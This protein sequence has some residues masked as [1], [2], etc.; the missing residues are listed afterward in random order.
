MLELEKA[1]EISLDLIKPLGSQTIDIINAAGRYNSSNLKS[2]V[3]LPGFDNSAMD[4]YAIISSDLKQANQSNPVTLNCI[5]IAPAGTMPDKKIKDGMCIR[6]FTGSPIP[7]GANAVIMQE[8]CVHNDD[9]TIITSTSV[10]PWQ[11]IRIRGEDIRKG[12]N[13]IF[14]GEQLNA[15]AIALLNATGH[16]TAQVGNQ[17]RIGLIATGSEL[18]DPPNKINPGE[19]YESNRTM[20]ASMITQAN[21]IPKIYPIV[22]DDLKKTISALESALSENDLIIT[23]GGVSVG[24]H[25][26]IKPALEEIGGSI[27]FWKVS[28]KPGKPFMLGQANEKTLFGLPGNPGS[29]LTTFL[30]LVRPAILKLQGASNIHLMKRTGLL[31]DEINNNGERRHFIR[32]KIDEN[33]HVSVIGNQR[34]HMLGSLSKTNGLIDIAP[35]SHLANGDKVK[36]L[37]IPN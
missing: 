6:I 9:N 8:D 5:G 1:I 29:A 34:S 4:G 2:K 11:N 13:L 35:N 15:G 18:I 19:I 3:D 31:V 22:E 14:E 36:V 21:G 26:H 25:D 27:D 20:L 7:E 16:K 10:K 33:S 23:T 17:P 30:L 12:D 32:V 24:D 28:M 37:M